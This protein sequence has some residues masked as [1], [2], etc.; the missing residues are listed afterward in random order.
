MAGAD[1]LSEP[2]GV[3]IVIPGDWE[4][5]VLRSRLRDTRM[6]PSP[7]WEWDPTEENR[8]G[9]TLDIVPLEAQQAISQTQETEGGVD[10]RA[11]H[12]L[13]EWVDQGAEDGMFTFEGIDG[14]TYEATFEEHI[15]PLFTEPGAW[16][17]D[18]APCIDCHYEQS[19]DSDHEMDMSTY[20]GIMA[21]AD[22]LSE[23]PGVPI[24]IPG[25]WENSVLRN[26]LR[27]TR[28]PPDPGWEWDPTEEN[29]DGPTLT[30]NGGEVRAVHLLGEWVDQGAENGAFTF[31]GIDGETYEAEFAEHILPL[32][33]EPDAWYADSAPCIDCHFEQSEDSD[34]EMDMS[35]YEGIMAGADVLSE[36][37]GVPIVIPG[38]WENSVLRSRLRDTRMPPDPGWEWDPTEENRDGPTLN[39][40]PHGTQE[41]TAQ[42]EEPEKG[43]VAVDGQE[44]GALTFSKTAL[45]FGPLPLDTTS[46]TLTVRLENSDALSVTIERIVITGDAAQDYALHH[47]CPIVLDSGMSCEIAVRFTPSVDGTRKAMLTVEHDA[48][49]SPVTFALL[50]NNRM[51]IYLP[52]V[53]VNPYNPYPEP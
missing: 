23:P 33:T 44:Q 30:I 50:A 51:G 40:V 25:D 4:N 48:V 37:P 2:P 22:V 32:F 29:R 49:G 39:I 3:P 11:V 17:A 5:S 1:V 21:G 7:G 31:A 10:V 8:D 43:A 27:D 14:E 28:M 38:D 45:Q 12:L 42:A 34:H 36:P 6:P 41:A 52:V 9:P 53:K 26:R 35:S 16:Y 18:S 15:L 24:V 19:E 20:E 46:P 13:G 47:A